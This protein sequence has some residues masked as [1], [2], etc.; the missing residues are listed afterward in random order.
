M[1]PQ[2][3]PIT[4]GDRA[5]DLGAEC[6]FAGKW[7]I[8]LELARRLMALQASFPVPLRIIS[9]Y[10]TPAQ[11]EELRREGRPTADNDKSTHLSC[12]ATGADLDFSGLEPS[13]SDVAQLGAAAGIVGLRWGGGSV[14]DP[15]TGIPL[16]WN[17]F[18]LGP[19]KPGS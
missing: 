1:L 6:T 18:D 14:V 15:S 11:Q 3:I 13:K 2:P 16:D 10:R 9:G 17:H 7:L 19:R 12:P 5:T 8:D 4:T